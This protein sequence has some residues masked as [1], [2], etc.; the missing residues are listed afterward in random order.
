MPAFVYFFKL[1]YPFHLSNAATS[2]M[3]AA[4]GGCIFMKT[5]ILKTIGGF[6]PIKDAL[7]DDCAL[8]K[9]VKEAGFATWIGLSRSVRSIRPYEN[10]GQI[11]NM[12]ARTAFTQ[13]RYSVILLMGCTLLMGLVFGVPA[14]F[15][16]L[17]LGSAGYFALFAFAGMVVTYLPTL[18]FYHRSPVWALCLPL[19]AALFLSMTWNSA[20]RY[21]KGERSR[22]KNRTYYN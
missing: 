9:R 16:F 1:L 5:A 22:W 2:K 7:I 14:W 20:F 11:W 4:A 19:T 3:A 13:L 12:V 17:G 6:E 15:P 21:W 10:I 8:A 18:L